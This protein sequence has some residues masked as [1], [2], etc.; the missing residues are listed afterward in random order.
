MRWDGVSVMVSDLVVRTGAAPSARRPR[1]VRRVVRDLPSWPIVVLFTG[2]GG[3]WLL[4]LSAFV[5]PIMAV[6][7]ALFMGVRGNIIVPRGFLLWVLFVVIAIGAAVEL[8][9]PVRYIGFGVRI[10]NYIGAGVILL[11]VVNCSRVRTPDRLIIM[12]MVGYLATVVVGGWL[13][14][15]VPEGRLTTPTS[16]VLPRGLMDNDYVRELVRPSFAEVQKPWGSPVAFT[17]PSAPFAYTNGWGCNMALLVPFAAA[18]MTVAR[19][20]GKIVTALLLLAALLPAFRTLNRGMFLAVIIAVSYAAVRYAIRGR[21]GPL[22]TLSAGM[23]LA[24]V[25]GA[26]TGVAAQLAMRLQYSETNLGRMTIY[27]EAFD[28]ALASPILGNGS[29]RPS[30]TL[31]ISIGTQGQ[32]WNVMFSY[33]FVA[34]AAYLGWFAYA[35]WVSRRARTPVTLWMHIVLILALLTTVYYGYDGPQLAVV[36]VAA[37]LV[38]RPSGGTR[39]P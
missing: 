29:P 3:W 18:A 26:V 7:M 24:V 14:V 5:V 16:M 9:A 37:G 27:G 2:F 39:R 4:G 8:N 6:V 10:S 31:N 38:L 25:L 33:G 20:W 35:V 32:L 12:A 13:G 36:M 22:L 30:S 1:P 11:Y 21:F 34:L 19:R 28:G 17:R 15:L 23:G